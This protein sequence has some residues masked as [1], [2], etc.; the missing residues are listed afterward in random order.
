[1]ILVDTSFWIAVDRGT[2]SID[3]YIPTEEEVATCPTVIMELLRGID[4]R[5]VYDTTRS[6]LFEV[7]L[8][9]SPT[10]LERFEQAAN[11]YLTCRRAGVTPSVP[12]LLIASCA[13]AHN[14]QLLHIDRDFDHIARVAPLKLFTRS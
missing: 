4:E 2:A 3:D 8:L 12:D 14:V 7:D 10:P 11:L 5:G 9:D 6:L 13:I 1:M